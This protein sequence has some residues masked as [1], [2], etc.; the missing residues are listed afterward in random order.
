MGGGGGGG[1]ATRHHIYIYIHMLYIH[2]YIYMYT[3]MYICI[4]VYTQKH[5]RPLGC[6][7]AA[8]AGDDTGPENSGHSLVYEAK[9][10]KPSP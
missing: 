6:D 8:A 2:I 7:P 5:K 3:D 10:T 9:N 1:P 4:G